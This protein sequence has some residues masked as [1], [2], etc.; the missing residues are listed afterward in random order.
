MNRLLIGSDDK[1][2]LL[3]TMMVED[4]DRGFTLIDPTGTLAEEIADRA[5]VQ[6]TC[7]LDPADIEHPFGFNVLD[8]VPENDRH[9]VAKEICAFFDVVFPEGP[10]T[11]SRARSNYLLLNCLRLLMDAPNPNFLS[12]PKLLSDSAYRTK[13]LGHCKDQV[14]LEF[15]EAEFP[16]WKPEDLLPLKSKVGELLTSPV[17]RNIIGQKHSTFS[18]SPG[19]IIIAN[20][21]RSKIGD[22]TAFLLASLLLARSQGPLYINGLGFFE[23]DHLA[24]ILRQDRVTV[25]LQFLEELPKK[26]QQ[27]VLAIDDKYVFKTTREDAERLAFYVGVSNPA[28]LTDLSTSEAR[29]MNEVILLST[30]PTA[31]RLEANRRRSR[32]SFTRPRRVIENSIQHYLRLDG[33]VQR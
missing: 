5:P 17:I 14:V 23:G 12:I 32:A 4:F 21:D 7:Y 30:P 11:L 13:C 3:L 20:L 18:L 9:K 24:G 16:A 1:T 29:G 22:Q 2:A 15:W 33:I 8:G 27:A 19:N 6:R 28:V 25:A 10:T 26:L 31:K